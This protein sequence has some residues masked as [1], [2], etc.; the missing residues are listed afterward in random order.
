MEQNER[1]LVVDQLNSSRDHLG[2]LVEGLTDA[3]WRY[4]PGE[5][6]WSI[7]QCIEHVTRVEKRINGMIGK[8]LEENTQEPAKATAEQKAKDADVIRMLPD[9]SVPRKAPEVAQPIGEW[10]DAGALFADFQATRHNTTEFASTTQ[11]ELRNF[12]LPHGFFGEVDCYQWLLMLGL[13]AT[14]HAQ[15]IEEIKAAPGYPQSSTAAS[16]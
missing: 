15:Q 16:K 6:R 12:F 9:R 1:Q 14:R 11:G 3:Q 2:R 10:T 4:S 8:K 13:H 5:G 7:G